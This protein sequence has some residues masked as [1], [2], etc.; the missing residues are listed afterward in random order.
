MFALFPEQS[1][2]N[3]NLVA[4]FGLYC[5]KEMVNRAQKGEKEQYSGHK[6]IKIKSVT[7]TTVES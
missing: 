5:H 1:I 6:E 4:L 3:K 7:F 2:Q